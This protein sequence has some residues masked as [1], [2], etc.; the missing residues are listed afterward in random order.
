MIVLDASAGLEL[1]FNTRLGKRIA[2]TIQANEAA[3]HAPHLIDL[4]IAHTLRRYLL[5][6]EISHERAEAALGAWQDIAITRHSHIRFL[7]PIWQ[8]RNNLT[9]YD[10]AYVALAEALGAVLV[11]CDSKLGN[12]SGVDIQVEVIQ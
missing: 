7:K 1:L 8:R 4:E 5:A 11:T 12:A 2:K 6:K 3:L 10:A 9:A